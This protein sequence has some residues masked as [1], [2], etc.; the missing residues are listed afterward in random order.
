M[1]IEIR[2][3]L[4][5]LIAGIVLALGE[6]SLAWAWGLSQSAELADDPTGCEC[7]VANAVDVE[8]S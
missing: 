4:L 5:T 3:R 6:I 1:K 2:T 8:R 7:L